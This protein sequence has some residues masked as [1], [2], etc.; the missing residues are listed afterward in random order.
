MGVTTST[1]NAGNTYVPI[2]TASGTGSSAVFTFNSIPQTYTD[3]RVVLAGLGG[4]S[5]GLSITLNNDSSSLYS[6]TSLYGDGGSAGSYRRTGYAGFQEMWNASAS[7]PDMV[8]MDLM[9]YANSNVYKTA[10]LNAFTVASFRTE[11]HVG[12]YRSTTAVTRIDLTALSNFPTGT[13]AT[14]YG[15]QA[16]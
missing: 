6:Y 8:T 2:Q 9:S 7:V 15:I 10:L 12:L 11:K 13:I 5:G 14:L 4:A 16:A 3:L 1:A